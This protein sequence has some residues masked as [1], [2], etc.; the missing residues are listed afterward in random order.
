M[1]RF[2]YI[3]SI[4]AMLSSCTEFLT[5][6]NT[7]KYSVEYVYGTPEGLELAVDALYARYRE[8]WAEGECVTP[9]ALIRATDIVTSNGGTGNYF[10]IYDPNNLRAS[11]GPVLNMWRTMYSII[12]NANAIIA[13]AEEMEEG[14]FLETVAQARCFRAQ[15][16]LTLIRTFDRIWL[17][18]EPTVPDNINDKRRYFAADQKDVFTTGTVQSGYGTSYSGQVGPVDQG[19]PDGSGTGGYDRQVRS[20][21]AA[22]SR[23]GVL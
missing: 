14:D 22:A 15:S 12:G 9:C 18:T 10:G 2:I 17:N 20:L 16:Y 5:E 6:E 8:Y 1:K 19:L 7:T 3:L 23:Q 4:I 21:F 11:A 13:A